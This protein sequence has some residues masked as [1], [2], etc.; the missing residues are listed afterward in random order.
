MGKYC[1]ERKKIPLKRKKS[2]VKQ[3]TE[4]IVKEG[5]KKEWKKEASLK[6]RK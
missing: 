4:N 5:K 2:I 1:E 3:K 6:K